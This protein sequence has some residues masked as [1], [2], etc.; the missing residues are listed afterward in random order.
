MGWNCA[1]VCAGSL[2]LLAFLYC[3]FLRPHRHQRSRYGTHFSVS[4]SRSINYR[5]A[6][7]RCW[8]RRQVALA[9]VPP[10]NRSRPAMSLRSHKRALR[11]RGAAQ[12]RPTSRSRKMTRRAPLSSSCVAS[13]R[14]RPA[15]FVS[16]GRRSARHFR[17][18]R[19][20]INN[21][22]A[23]PSYAWSFALPANS[24]A[25]IWPDAR[26][27]EHC[28]KAHRA[29][30]ELHPRSACDAVREAVD[31]FHSDTAFLLPARHAWHAYMRFTAAT[32]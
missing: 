1:V 3:W 22:T 19:T 15:R 16:S 25:S 5:T 2:L 10:L 32:I 31:M 23:F 29:H 17:C 21:R 24:A 9:F 26:L 8:L 13:Q 6:F 28:M 27:N 12:Q 11:K 30:S 14:R 18:P 7:K 4:R 20:G